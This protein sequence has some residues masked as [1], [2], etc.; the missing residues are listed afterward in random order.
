MCRQQHLSAAN[1]L[2]V[3]SPLSGCDMSFKANPHHCTMSSSNTFLRREKKPVSHQENTLHTNLIMSQMGALSA[4]YVFVN[5]VCLCMPAHLRYSTSNQQG[6]SSSLLMSKIGTKKKWKWQ[7]PAN[8]NHEN[9][10]FMKIILSLHGFLIIL[11]FFLQNC[12]W[13]EG[14]MWKWQAGRFYISK[15]SGFYVHLDFWNTHKHAFGQSFY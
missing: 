12:W 9:C 5:L 13:W 6:E 7:N 8:T 15:A 4:W 14:L 1:K 3:F 10:T 11:S 2:L